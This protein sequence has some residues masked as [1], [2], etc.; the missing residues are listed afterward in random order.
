MTYRDVFLKAFTE[1]TGRPAAEFDA[2]LTAGASVHGITSLD[3]ELP[4]SPEQAQAFL[5]IL[6]RGWETEI[7][8]I[9]ARRQNR[10]QHARMN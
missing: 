2:M 3:D 1:G 7:A 8:A 4:L 9:N 10:Q 5:T 6:R